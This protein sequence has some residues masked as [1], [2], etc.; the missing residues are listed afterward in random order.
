VDEQRGTADERTD[1]T[2]GD[3]AGRGEPGTDIGTLGVVETPIPSA[4][5]PFAA[6]TSPPWRWRS[7]CRPKTGRPR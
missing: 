4:K 6:I 1:A 5:W 2:R 3:A 7:S